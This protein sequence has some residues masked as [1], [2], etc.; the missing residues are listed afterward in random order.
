MLL[1]PVHEIDSAIKVDLHKV[2][3]QQAQGQA[4]VAPGVVPNMYHPVGYP[5]YNPNQILNVAQA[6]VYLHVQ[7]PLPPQPAPPQLHHAPVRRRQA[8]AHQ[9]QAQVPRPQLIGWKKR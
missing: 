5:V 2:P 3:V 6:H 4:V 9:R 1:F 7:L 8:V